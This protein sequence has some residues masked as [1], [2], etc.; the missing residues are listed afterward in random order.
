M[1]WINTR[2]YIYSLPYKIANVFFVGIYNL[3]SSLFILY[4]KKKVKMPLHKPFAKPTIRISNTTPVYCHDVNIRPFYYLIVSCEYHFNESPREQ[5][6]ETLW[7]DRPPVSYNIGKS[8]TQ[9][10]CQ[11][12]MG[13]TPYLRVFHVWYISDKRSLHG[14]GSYQSWYPVTFILVLL[15]GIFSVLIIIPS[16]IC[17]RT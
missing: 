2:Q 15:I 6:N 3:C 1:A 4:N 7:V 5:M 16:D 9:K 10:P 8:E 12:Y 17:H 11:Y 14:L 13:S